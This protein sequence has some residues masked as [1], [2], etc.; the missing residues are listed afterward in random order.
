MFVSTLVVSPMKL[1]DEEYRFQSMAQVSH[2][3]RR[4]QALDCLSNQ[5]YSDRWWCHSSR[6]WYDTLPTRMRA[7]LN[8]TLSL[9]MGST[10]RLA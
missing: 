2:K 10:F 5:R 7:V 9:D 4:L 8:L 1:P 3:P 6:V